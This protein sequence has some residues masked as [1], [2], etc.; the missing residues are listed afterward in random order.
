MH[1][2][3]VVAMTEIL[4]HWLAGKLYFHSTARTLNCGD[5]HGFP[6]YC[7]EARRSMDGGFQYTDTGQVHASTRPMTAI[8]SHALPRSMLASR[9]S[10]R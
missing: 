7:N 4:H 10:G 8:E 5:H 1:R 9:A 3:A 2:L 6:W